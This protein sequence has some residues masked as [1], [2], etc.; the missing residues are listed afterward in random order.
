MPFLMPEPAQPP[1]PTA[2]L[3]KKCPE[4]AQAALETIHRL[5]SPYCKDAECLIC[6]VLA[7]PA[8]E[9]LHFHHDGCPADCGA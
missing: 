3:H 8:G 4:H 7:C 1:P 9:P 6:G 5:H 2:P